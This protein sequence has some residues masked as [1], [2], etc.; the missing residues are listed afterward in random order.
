MSEDTLRSGV[1]ASLH[2]YL[3]KSVLDGG[4]KDMPDIAIINLIPFFP[5]VIIAGKNPIPEGGNDISFSAGDYLL[6]AARAH[7][8]EREECLELL[9]EAIEADEFG[10]MF[11]ILKEFSDH[12][13]ITASY[14]VADDEDPNLAERLFEFSYNLDRLGKVFEELL[15]GGGH[16]HHHH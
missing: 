12:Y 13:F 5:A 15:H 10:G 3:D 1:I 6:D 2:N 16:H 9:D 11:T 8:M 4:N 7:G 14:Q